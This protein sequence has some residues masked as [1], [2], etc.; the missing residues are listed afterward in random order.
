MRLYTPNGEI[1]EANF[2]VTRIRCWRIMTNEPSNV[3][4]GLATGAS[5]LKAEKSKLELSFEYLV[6]S[7]RLEW[8]T[9]VSN[10]VI[11]VDQLLKSNASGVNV[12]L[13][14]KAK[15]RKLA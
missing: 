13:I 3:V 12:G 4:P 15:A 7:E 6:T 10:Q 9:I 1:Q 14:V 11:S 5:I 2:K 8:I